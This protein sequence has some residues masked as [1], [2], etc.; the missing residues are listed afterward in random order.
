VTTLATNDG[1][2]RSDHGGSRFIA[3]HCAAA[4]LRHGY[5]V[6]VLD[7]L[8]PQIHGAEREPPNYLDRRVE[9]IVGDIRSPKAVRRALNDA[10]AVF[11]LAARVGVGQ[12]M[13]EVADYTDVNSRGYGG[14]A[15]SDDRE[16]K[17]PPFRPARGGSSMSIYGEGRYRASDGR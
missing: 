12:S 5:R 9:L 6:R 1:K 7:N 17:T 13:Y 8:D 11:H 10:D 3:S 14:I 2:N 4:L 15:R 16:G